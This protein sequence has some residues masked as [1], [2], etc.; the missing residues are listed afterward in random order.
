MS[1]LNT[2]LVIG[3]SIYG[4]N[5]ITR[6][7]Y[8]SILTLGNIME[9]LNTTT[10]IDT[11][12]IQVD[13]INT[14]EQHERLVALVNFI[15][16]TPSLYYRY[17]DTLIGCGMKYRTYYIYCNGK[18]LA[19]IST[20]SFQTLVNRHLITQY[21]IRILFA[22]LKS[23]N[24][25]YDKGSYE[26]LMRLCAFLNGTKQERRRGG[27]IPFKIKEL[28][29]CIDV[30]CSFNN[31]WATCVKRAGRTNY[32]NA[33]DSQAYL[34]TYYIEKIA[35]NK[36]SN[37]VQRAYLYDKQHKEDLSEPISRFEV[38]LQSN[39]FI[40]H[41][42][43][44]N[45]IKKAL[46]RYYFMYFDDLNIKAKKMAE[47]HRLEVLEQQKKIKPK[48]HRKTLVR[49]REINKLKLDPYRLY[50]DTEYIESFIDNMYLITLDDL[51]WKFDVKVIK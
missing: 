5:S 37:A 20:G 44:I 47:Y 28:D 26:G 12:G 36:L 41:G 18:I 14:Y 49:S 50:F 39:Y 7:N 46:N 2:L 13:C 24:D 19:T 40:N 3:I 29:C 22:G 45:S 15:V 11:V 8:I 34:T 9:T 10:Q 16:A 35:S 43:N 32:Y 6:M 1:Y 4:L 23:Y 33:N 21:Y 30:H 42:F 48:E 51:E 25:I 27:R 17:K 31:V 38:K